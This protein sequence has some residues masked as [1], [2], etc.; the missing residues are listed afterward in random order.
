MKLQSKQASKQ[1]KPLSSI[2]YTKCQNSYLPK[3][4]WAYSLI[5]VKASPSLSNSHDLSIIIKSMI[6][7]QCSKRPHPSPPTNVICLS[8]HILQTSSLTTPF[9]VFR[10]ACVIIT[11][12]FILMS[13]TGPLVSPHGTWHSSA[14]INILAWVCLMILWDICL[15]YT[16]IYKLTNMYSN[17]TWH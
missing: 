11:F 5:P 15:S 9:L 10:F 17:D 16:T 7:D 1:I 8:C 4:S 14:L 3:L 6:W 13:T 2:T 12:A